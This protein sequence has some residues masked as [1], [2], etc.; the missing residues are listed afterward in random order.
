[1]GKGISPLI[2]KKKGL[3][4]KTVTAWIITVIIRAEI[5]TYNGS[6]TQTYKGIKWVANKLV[7]YGKN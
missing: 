6:K 3:K 2:R 7:K 1:V 4:M 5:K